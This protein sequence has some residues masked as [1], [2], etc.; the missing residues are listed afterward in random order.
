MRTCGRLGKLSLRLLQDRPASI[1]RNT[2]AAPATTISSSLEGDTAR[3]WRPPPTIDT[4]RNAVRFS[5]F[6]P[7]SS[8]RYTNRPKA[9]TRGE[10][11]AGL[12]IAAPFSGNVLDRPAGAG[13][14]TVSAGAA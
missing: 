12:R 11:P 7:L 13:G 10:A 1:E 3:S 8:E 14:A 2:P 9:Y 4:P 6:L 5:Q